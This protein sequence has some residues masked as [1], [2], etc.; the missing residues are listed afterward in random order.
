LNF[1]ILNIFPKKYIDHVVINEYGDDGEDNNNNN[2]NIFTI[3]IMS[4][5]TK[6]PLWPK[7]DPLQPLGPPFGMS[8]LPLFA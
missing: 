2:N 5:I 3:I 6:G 4:H 1:Y 8:S 7:L